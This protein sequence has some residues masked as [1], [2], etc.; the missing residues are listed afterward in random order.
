M[1]L[2]LSIF[3]LI[4]FSDA[5]ALPQASEVTPRNTRKGYQAVERDTTPKLLLSL[6]G[7]TSLP[8]SWRFNFCLGL[9]KTLNSLLS[10]VV[11]LRRSSGWDPGLGGEIRVWISQVS[12]RIFAKIVKLRGTLWF[13]LSTEASFQIQ[14]FQSMSFIF[15]LRPMLRDRNCAGKS[16]KRGNPAQWG[17]INEENVGHIFLFFFASLIFKN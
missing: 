1:F 6:T 3:T 12:G 11:R 15:P 13:H 7:S 8:S 16:L 9:L 10:L 17:T 14:F 2:F 4:S 5:S